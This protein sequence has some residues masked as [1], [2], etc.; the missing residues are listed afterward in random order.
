MNLLRGGRGV[1]ATSG[2]ESLVR[3]TVR[4]A[5]V[6]SCLFAAGCAAKAPLATALPV[7]AR[8]TRPA[9]APVLARIPEYGIE[10]VGLH[11][12]GGGTLVDF[13]YRVV[14]PQKAAVLLDRNQKIH[15]LDPAH[16]LL[17]TVPSLAYVGALRQTAVAP[18]AGKTYFIL[19]GNAARS[20]KSGSQVTLAIGD[21][22]VE[23][24][25]VM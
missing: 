2:R 12:T 9:P 25:V 4:A 21:H 7:V 19:F 1:R 3:G 10:A 14:D 11:V 18:Q 17:L 15:L 24:L 23:G 5:V 13:R 16:N 20:V 8:P 22:R 6:A